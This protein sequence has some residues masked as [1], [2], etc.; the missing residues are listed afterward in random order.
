MAHTIRVVLHNASSA[1]YAELARKLAAINVVDVIRGANGATY[2]LP[3][4]E[5]RYEGAGSA[6]DVRDRC[7]Q[8]AS[9]VAPCAVF[10]TEG[11]NCAWTG[12]SAVR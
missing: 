2:K 3:D 1:Q 12:L 6:A 11:A 4:A 5:Y 9:T 7:A 10:V 8:I